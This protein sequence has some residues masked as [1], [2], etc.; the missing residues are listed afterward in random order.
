MRVSTIFGVVGGILAL[1]FSV[2]GFFVFFLGYSIAQTLS[3]KEPPDPSLYIGL[4]WSGIFGSFISVLG[5]ILTMRWRKIGGMVMV[6]GALLILNTLIN[7]FIFYFLN[8]VPFLLVISGA[9]Y[10]FTR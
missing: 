7:G 4:S 2:V 10:K 5:G 8:L 9:V 3:G 6:L 1:I